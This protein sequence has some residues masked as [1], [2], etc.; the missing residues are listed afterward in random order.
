MEPS[1]PRGA[2]ILWVV[3]PL[4]SDEHEESLYSLYVAG[5]LHIKEQVTALSKSFYENKKECELYLC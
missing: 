2:Q 3:E 4:N 5:K 1:V